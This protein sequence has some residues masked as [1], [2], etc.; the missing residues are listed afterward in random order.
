ML[1]HAAIRAVFLSALLALAACSPGPNAGIIGGG[2]EPPPPPPGPDTDSTEPRTRYEFNNRCVVLQSV[3]N[4]RFVTQTDGRFAATATVLSGAEAFYFKPSA[5]GDYLLF[6]RNSAL[7]AANTPV[8]SNDL[9]SAS[10]ANILTVRA[11]N[12]RTSYVQPPLQ[13]RE[14]TPAEIDAYRNFVD[15]ESMGRIFTLDAAA[16]GQRLQIGADSVLTQS[17]AQ[18]ETAPAQQFRLLTA[19][20]CATFPEAN[21]NATGETFKGNTASGGV[22]GMADVHVHLSATN[23]LANAQYGDPFHRFV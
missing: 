9:A 21:S 15:P 5:L 12:D 13:D 11:L 6:T 17:V 8:T 14:P 22:L 16:T 23:F 2:G 20:G 7:L 3:A 1:R 10:N 18:A 19:T 4:N